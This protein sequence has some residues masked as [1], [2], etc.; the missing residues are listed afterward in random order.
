MGNKLGKE[1]PEG[2]RDQP[3]PYDFV[4]GTCG[5]NCVDPFWENVQTHAHQLY[6][7]GLGSLGPCS[8]EDWEE[9]MKICGTHNR[10]NYPPGDTGIVN[11]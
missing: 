2:E 6:L 3:S 5:A 1:V 8:L 9:V 4:K 10:H 7:S 11:I